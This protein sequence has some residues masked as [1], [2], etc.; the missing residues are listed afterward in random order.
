MLGLFLIGKVLVFF[1]GFEFEDVAFMGFE[2]SKLILV[3]WIWIYAFHEEGSR[4]FLKIKFFLLLEFLSLFE[5]WY[6]SVTWGDWFLQVKLQSFLVSISL[7]VSSYDKSV[8]VLFFIWLLI[9]GVF[10][11]GNLFFSMPWSNGYSV[12][13]DDDDDYDKI[14]QV[15]NVW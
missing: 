14:L 13:D 15:M 2:V 5:I 1:L 9:A 3:S 12:D 11:I 8:R 10:L 4:N 6:K 7:I